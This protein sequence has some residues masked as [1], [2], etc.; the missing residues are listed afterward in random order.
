MCYSAQIEAD[1][2]KYVREFGA[3]MDIDEFTRLF[4]ERV[5]G[6]KALVPKGVEDAFAH[7]ATDEERQAKTFIDEFRA[8]QVTKLEQAIFK[9][10]ER[11]AKAER[12][13]QTK[14]TK[15]ATE[16]KRIATN[17]IDWSLRQLEDLRRTTPKDRDSRIFRSHYA[18]VMVMENGRRVIKPMRYLCRIAGKPANYDV[19]FPGTYNSRLDNLEG[20]WKPLFGHTHGILIVDKF[21][22]NV[23]RHN[24]EHR[25]LAEGEEEENVVLEFAPTPQHRMLVA[26]LWSHWSNG[27]DPDLLSFAAITDEPPPEVAAAG[28]NRCI[29]P[30]KPENV[31]AWLNPDPANLAAQYAILEDRD[32]PYYEHRL[33]A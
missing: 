5:Q 2:R 13:L 29:I 33:A 7:P 30:I 15:A 25:E 12:V 3:D 26:C 16:D 23:K 1:Y 4:F 9:Q 10:R 6:S 19:R 17:K 32:R 27:K 14:V 22:E 11:L 28:H 20:F 31:D 18:P 8:Q 24:L 21:F